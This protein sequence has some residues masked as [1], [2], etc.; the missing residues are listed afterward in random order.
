MRLFPP[1]FLLSLRSDPDGGAFVAVSTTHGYDAARLLL[2][3]FMRRVREALNASLIFAGIPNRDFLVAWTPDFA[4]RWGF[5]TKI[6]QDFQSRPHPLTG[7]LF[8][9]N[10]SGVRLADSAAMRDHGR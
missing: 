7:A 9:S 8:A 2:P 3:H 4:P 5:A 10:D 6:A 1:R